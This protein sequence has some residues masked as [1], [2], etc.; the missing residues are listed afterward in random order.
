MVATKEGLTLKRVGE[1]TEQ[2][3]PEFLWCARLLDPLSGDDAP[4]DGKPAQAYRRLARNP[5]FSIFEMRVVVFS[6]EPRLPYRMGTVAFDR[7]RP[8][9]PP[10]GE[11]HHH[12]R[13]VYLVGGNNMAEEG[14][15]INEVLTV[16]VGEDRD[17][18]P[19]AGEGHLL[20]DFHAVDRDVIDVHVEVLNQAADLPAERV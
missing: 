2:I 5:N 1:F 4:H 3:V 7:C 19:V 9:H 18:A 17:L 12:G 15:R 11:Q 20:A 10:L 16:F 6:A 13:P 8:S 14:R